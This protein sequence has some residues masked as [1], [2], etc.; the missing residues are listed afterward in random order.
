VPSP[1]WVVAAADGVVVLSEDGLVELDVGGG[2]S[3]VYLHVATHE[4]APLGTVV[5]AGERL[6]HPSCE[7]GRATA[8]HLHLARKYNGEWMAADGPVPFV[9]SGWVARFGAGAYRGTLTRGDQVI[10][11][12]ACATAVTRLWL[13]P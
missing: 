4:R 11:A 8:S 10:E 6:G 1:E 7:G 12:C 2:W 13:E 3:V 5:R 9:M